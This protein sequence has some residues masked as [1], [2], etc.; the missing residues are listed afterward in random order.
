MKMKPLR[1][2]V[3]IVCN[4]QFGRRVPRAVAAERAGPLE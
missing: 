2:G 3:R 4:E 1:A